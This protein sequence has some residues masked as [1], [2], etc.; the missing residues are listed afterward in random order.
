MQRCCVTADCRDWPDHPSRF[1]SC[2]AVSTAGGVKRAGSDH[3]AS[4]GAE[5][6]TRP[7]PW[8]WAEQG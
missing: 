6:S 2:K 1:L 5:A 8:S 7:G 3:G 4:A